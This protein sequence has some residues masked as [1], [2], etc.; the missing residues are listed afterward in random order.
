MR[1][2]P[3]SVRAQIQVATV[4][5]SSGDCAQ[6]LGWVTA[7]AKLGCQCVSR[8]CATGGCQ[9]PAAVGDASDGILTP[10]IKELGVNRC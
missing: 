2:Q 1:G 4:H 5:R 7:A 3:S 9:Q 10:T 6:S 8:Y